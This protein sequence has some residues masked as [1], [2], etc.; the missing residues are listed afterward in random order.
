MFRVQSLDS[1]QEEFGVR[2][3]PR[4]MPPGVERAS[5]GLFSKSD[6]LTVRCDSYW[7]GKRTCG[8]SSSP[9]PRRTICRPHR[10]G[11]GHSGQTF[12]ALGHNQ[13]PPAPASGGQRPVASP[14]QVP[15]INRGWDDYAV[16]DRRGR[17]PARGSLALAV[18]ALR[19]QDWQQAAANLD[20]ACERHPHRPL[21][22]CSRHGATSTTATSARSER[23][24]RCC[25]RSRPAAG[26]A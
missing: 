23:C 7:Q 14:E 10:G 5:L 13:A 25:A 24:S 11:G 1:Q 16:W 26:R 4:G 18:S 20:A 9:S 12:G 8:R 17:R 2:L 21:F 3:V 22:F 15:A 19:R 6:G